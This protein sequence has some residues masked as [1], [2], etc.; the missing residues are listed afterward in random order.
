M[1]KIK[2]FQQTV[3]R[4]IKEGRMPSAEQF[5]DAVLEARADFN[6]EVTAWREFDQI[7]ATDTRTD[8]DTPQQKTMDNRSKR[9][10]LKVM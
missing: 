9:K 2:Q 4:L 1:N 10:Q 8:T 6:M 5:L 7:M 3:D